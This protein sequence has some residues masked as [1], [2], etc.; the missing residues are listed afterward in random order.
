MTNR[1][2]AVLFLVA[3]LVRGVVAWVFFGSVDL[4]NAMLYTARLFDGA[5]PSSIPVPYLPGV[6]Q[7]LLWISGALAIE[8]VL[9]LSF[10]YKL[11]PL[12]FDAAIAVLVLDV[13]GRKAGWLYAFAPVPLIITCI[14]AQWDAIAFELLLLALLI[15]G[16][17]PVLAGV[18][19]MLSVLVKPIAIPFAPLLLTKRTAAGMAAA[20]AAYL[21]ALYAIG[22]PL[23]WSSIRGVVYY[24]TWG[25]Q[26]FGLPIITGGNVNRLL[27]LAPLLLLVPMYWKGRISRLEAVTLSLAFILASSGM[28]P[29]YLM[30]IVPFLLIG[31]YRRYAAIYSLAAGLFLLIYYHHSGPTGFNWENLGA[32]APLKPL[33]WLVPPVTDTAVFGF[34][35]SLVI[36]LSA[37]LFFVVQLLKALRAEPK[38]GQEEPRVSVVPTAVAAAVVVMALLIPAEPTAARF[39]ATVAEKTAHYAMKRHHGPGLRHPDEPTWVMD[40]HR[41]G[42]NAV[43]IGYAWVVLWSIAAWTAR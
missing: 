13:R 18:A 39:E 3:L 17:R 23:T 9:P 31:G 25:A 7:L 6:Y 15:A 2:R 11:F 12:V 22:D 38:H 16:R 43:T 37:L 27:T 10:A 28:S 41:S 32:F 40:G 34:L 20:G 8:T 4:T 42:L 36:P 14:H 1:D 24:A 29:Q 30:W 35:G 21:I 5:A 33:S 19:F 26:V